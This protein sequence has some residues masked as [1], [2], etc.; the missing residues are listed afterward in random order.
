[1]LVSA[2]CACAGQFCWKLSA[3]GKPVYILYGFLLYGA[4]SA[5]MIAA[6]KHGG[7]SQLQPILSVQYVFTALIAHFA[8]GEPVSPSAGIGIALIA[9]SVALLGSGGT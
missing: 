9:L 3:K 6:Y 4:G 5:A 7:V 2:L 1:M 8:L